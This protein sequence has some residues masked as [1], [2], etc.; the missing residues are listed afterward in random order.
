VLRIFSG[1]LADE[2]GQ[3]VVAG[4]EAPEDAAIQARLFHELALEA[5]LSPQELVGNA[6]QNHLLDR[7]INDENAFSLKAQRGVPEAMGIGL[8]EAVRGDLAE[9]RALYELEL[10]L[11]EFEPLGHRQ[12]PDI[13]RLLASVKAWPELLPVLAAYYHEHGTGVLAQHRA[14]RWDPRA[15]EIEPVRNPDTQRLEEL[16]TYDLERE[17]LLSNTEQFLAGHPSNNVLLYGERGTGKSSTVKA[18]L[19]RYPRLKMIEVAPGDL[20]DLPKLL[21][22]LAANPARFILFVDDLS[23]D[24]M[25]LQYKH[26]KAVLEGGLET[27]PDNVVIYATSNRRHLVKERFSDMTKAIVNDEIHQQDTV[28]EKLSLSDRFGI[29]LTFVTPDQERYVTIV[30]SI[31]EARGLDIDAA[32][33]RARAIRWA[34]YTNGF[35]GRTA[36]QFVDFLEGELALSGGS[37]APQPGSRSGP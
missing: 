18:L 32:D 21:P 4:R 5:E 34:M 23:F 27:K 14:F 26:L 1:V 31:A 37:G 9:L 24:E 10:G 33:L 16:Y 35:S 12:A 13:K 28:Q 2:I 20:A 29:T 6:W 22:A 11:G 17:L 7:I 25:E 3:L 36:R 30:H 19:Q 15:E 8:V